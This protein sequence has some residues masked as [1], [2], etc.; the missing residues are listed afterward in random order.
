MRACRLDPW[1]LAVLS[2]LLVSSS[3]AAQAPPD[4]LL[5]RDAV[6]YFELTANQ[7][8]AL[9]GIEASWLEYRASATERAD[10]IAME[11]EQETRR[12][13]LDPAALGQRYVDWKPSAASR[14]PDAC[15]L[16]LTR[17]LS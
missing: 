15:G 1:C 2:L 7:L 10:R 3:A 5:V 13:N 4:R 8:T 9:T 14:K 16:W 6:R 17:A 12:V 11:I